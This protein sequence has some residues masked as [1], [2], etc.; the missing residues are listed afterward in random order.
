MSRTAC[1]GRAVLST[2]MAFRPPVSAI[3]GAAGC[4]WAAM[5][6]LIPW[7][8]AVDPVKHTPATRASLT[9]AAPTLAPCPGRNC[10]ALRGT[11]AV[12][13]NSTARAPMRVVV[14]AGFAKT[15]FPAASAAAICPVKMAKG[16]FHGLIQVN[17]PR[18][19]CCKSGAWAA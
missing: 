18:A 12:W 15:P 3:K 4:R 19:G 9:R 10:R 5:A 7:A 13:S 16:K 11:P 17:T 8:V 14:S 6:R 1:S 2:I